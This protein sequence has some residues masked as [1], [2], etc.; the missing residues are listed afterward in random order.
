MIHTHGNKTGFVYKGSNYFTMNDL[1]NQDLSNLKFALLL[2]C[3]CGK[4][5]DESH[6]LNNNPVNIIEKMV[7]CGAETVVGFK[8]NVYMNECNHFAQELTSMLVNGLSIDD[9]IDRLVPRR[10]SFNHDDLCIAG[11]EDNCIR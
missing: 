1:T 9:A 2:A 6:I 4:D 11:N 7:L 5:Y 8:I 10:Y 3:D